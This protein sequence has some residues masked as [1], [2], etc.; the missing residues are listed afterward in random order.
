MDALGDQAVRRIAVRKNVV[1]QNSDTAVENFS[2]NR[3]ARRQ[4]LG[5]GGSLSRNCRDEAALFFVR[6][7]DCA[8]FGRN[9][10]E[11]TFEQ[12]FL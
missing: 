1:A 5:A 8:L 9:N 2:R 3:F 6:K 7:P 10:V 4:G 12:P 11:D